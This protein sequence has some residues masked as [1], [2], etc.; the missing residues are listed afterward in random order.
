[1]SPL[2]I[3]YSFRRCPYAMRARMALIVSGVQCEL[4]EVD[5]GKK[6]ADMLAVSPKGTVPV[7]LFPDGS[8]LQESLDI[9]LWAFS[10]SEMHGWLR[11]EAGSLSAM[12]ALIE[13][14]DGEFKAH[15]DRYKYPERY[16]KEHADPWHHYAEACD[17]I[18]RLESMLSDND[19]LYG[20]NPSLADAALFPFVR[21]FAAVD[22]DRFAG[23]GLPRLQT[24]LTGWQESDLFANAMH[25]QQVWQPGDVPVFLLTDQESALEGRT[26]A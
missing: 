25:K 2:P 1:M 7:L 24:W 17:L 4:R 26:A 15:L 10:L 8:V 3:L 9:M 22:P 14:N 5:L 23:L 16:A 20:S 21:Q 12:L 18:S 11:P 6:P 19:F 13:Q